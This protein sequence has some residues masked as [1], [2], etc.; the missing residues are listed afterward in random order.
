MRRRRD[1]YRH[2]QGYV[3]EFRI[4]V[5]FFRLA[6]VK[7][8][9]LCTVITQSGERGLGRID[10]ILYDDHRTVPL[11]RLER[12]W[13]SD[14]RESCDQIWENCSIRNSDFGKC[15]C[16]HYIDQDEFP[17]WI[18]SDCWHPV[19]CEFVGEAG[20]CTVGGCKPNIKISCPECTSR[21]IKTDSEGET[22]ICADCLHRW[23]NPGE[24]R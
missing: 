15:P 10:E 8:G 22:M 14:V 2:K 23:P 19:I 21:R 3:Q 4:P 9:Q 16:E 1:S 11:K 24:F 5:R 12:D 6:H 13:I 7:T 18:Q 20:G 17:H